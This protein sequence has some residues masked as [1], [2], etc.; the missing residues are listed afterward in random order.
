MWR[1]RLHSVDFTLTTARCVLRLKSGRDC[2]ICISSTGN[3]YFEAKPAQAR[4][5]SLEGV[6]YTV[7]SFAL[8]NGIRMVSRRDAV[9]VEIRLNLAGRSCVRIAYRRRLPHCL[10]GGRTRSAGRTCSKE[11]KERM[12]EAR[13]P[14]L[15]TDKIVYSEH[16]PYTLHSHRQNI[17]LTYLALQPLVDDTLIPPLQQQPLV[18]N[19]SIHYSY[20]INHG[21]IIRP[22]QL[23][24]RLYSWCRLC[25][26]LHCQQVSVSSV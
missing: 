26:W 5:F 19:T 23:C 2:I 15:R 7:R 11:E 20:G 3:N 18:I 25:L 1:K 21:G 8:C 4:R 12:R 9:A 24:L 10:R 13:F 16:S 22:P 14:L 6:G 17:T